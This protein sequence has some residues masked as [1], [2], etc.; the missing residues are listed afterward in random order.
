MGN[1]KSL[2]RH[3]PNFLTILNLCAGCIAIVYAFEGHMYTASLLIFIA[4]VFDFLDGFTAKLFKLVS[5]VGKELDSLADIVSFGVA[6]SIILFHL[7]KITISGQSLIFSFESFSFLET[8]ILFSAFLIAV[9]SAIRLAIFNV[10]NSSSEFFT[11][12]PTPACGLLIASIPLLLL[13]TQVSNIEKLILNLYFLLPLIV[14]L[15]FLLVSKFPMFSI[16]F[17]NFSFRDNK[18]R[19]IFIVISIVLFI[20]LKIPAIPIIFIFYIL[21]SA[22]NNWIYK[23]T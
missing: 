23:L 1:S 2:L 7:L 18:I 3:L 20:I 10:S 19:Y 9:F 22:F 21:L 11:G 8:I 4:A 17:K 15:S 6:P 12:L 14:L 5:E 13:D 16:K